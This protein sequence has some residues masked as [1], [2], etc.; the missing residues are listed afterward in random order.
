MNWEIISALAELFGALGLIISVIY[1]AL[2]VR[3]GTAT[4][5]RAAGHDVM[6]TINPLL[7]VLSSDADVTSIWM[8]GLADFE[9]LNGDEQVR[10]SCLLLMLTYSWDEALHSHKTKQL[11]D[12]ALERFTGSMHELA[13]LPGFR[14]WYGVRKAWLSKNIRDVLEQ[15]MGFNTPQS[16]FY[17]PAPDSDGTG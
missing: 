10:F 6:M 9:S 5:R 13:R 2:Q 7:T 11:D 3:N 12:W 15:E 14:S 16:P 17:K 4:A 8:R 1:L